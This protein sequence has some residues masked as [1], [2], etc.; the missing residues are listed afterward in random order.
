[1]K[2]SPYEYSVAINKV[3]S[4]VKSL[5]SYAGSYEEDLIK[6]AGS[7]RTFEEHLKNDSL[8]FK[9]DVETLHPILE[10]KCRPIISAINSLRGYEDFQNKSMEL[11]EMEDVVL[12]ALEFLKEH[13]PVSPQPRSFGDKVNSCKLISTVNMPL[14]WYY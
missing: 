13:K 10:S 7:V 4:T 8:N 12:N 3:I 9:R 14:L 6:L 11:D 5:Q 1:M 2:K